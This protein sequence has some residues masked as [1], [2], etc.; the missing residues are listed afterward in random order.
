MQSSLLV[1]KIGFGQIE[2]EGSNKKTDWAK[3]YCLE[4]TFTTSDMFAGFNE[5]HFPIVDPVTHKP[6]LALAEVIRKRFESLNPTAPIK[7]D[8][9]LTMTT[10]AKRQV[11]SI[12]GLA[13]VSK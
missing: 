7:M 12:S 9:L 11:L 2:D 8:F 13:P 5:V 1:T 10:S 3:V 4:P 6:N